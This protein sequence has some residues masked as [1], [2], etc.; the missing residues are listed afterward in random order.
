MDAFPKLGEGTV[1]I[2]FSLASVE[3]SDKLAVEEKT[4]RRCA[5]SFAVVA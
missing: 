1:C 3:K 5:V 4:Q 2:K